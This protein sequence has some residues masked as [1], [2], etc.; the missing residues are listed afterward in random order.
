MSESHATGV[1]YWQ[2]TLSDWQAAGRALLRSIVLLISLI[3]VTA[4]H[5]ARPG[6]RLST[7]GVPCTQELRP[8]NVS[9]LPCALRHCSPGIWSET[10]D[11]AS[12]FRDGILGRQREILHTSE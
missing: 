5:V 12:Q 8:V 7:L 1:G 2:H 3:T 6:Q 11:A 10:E 9:R 4:S